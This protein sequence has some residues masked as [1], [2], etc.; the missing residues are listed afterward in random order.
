MSFDFD[1]PV[2]ELRRL[3]IAELSARED[4]I[5]A[6]RGEF[7]AGSLPAPAPRQSVTMPEELPVSSE[8][9]DDDASDVAG[10]AVD[11]DTGGVDEVT[12]VQS[13]VALLAKRLGYTPAR[14]RL[15]EQKH[16]GDLQAMLTD[17]RTESGD[18]GQRPAKTAENGGNWGPG[19]AGDDFLGPD[20]LNF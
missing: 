11:A 20:D 16:E 7:V 5:R 6:R 14:M 15:L 13:D 19:E 8:V 12:R 10:P 9:D 18:G 2:S 3:A 1:G 17:L 4:L